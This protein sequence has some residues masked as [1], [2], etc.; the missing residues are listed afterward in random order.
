MDVLL[1]CYGHTLYA[2][3]THRDQKRASAS[4]KLQLRMV[5]SHPVDVGNE[6]SVLCKSSQCSALNH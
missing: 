2:C 3:N 4:L 5:V 6:T 1:A